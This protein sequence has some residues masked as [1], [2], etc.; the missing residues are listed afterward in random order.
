MA[1][2]RKRGRLGAVLAAAC[3]AAGFW[4]AWS[5][6]NFEASLVT[7]VA[8]IRDVTLP[9]DTTL[10][11]GAQTKVD[12]HYDRD[13]RK[14]TLHEGEAFFAVSFDA[15]PFLV[16][17]QKTLVTAIGTQFEVHVAHETVRVSVL[18][19]AVIVS[20]VPGS[21]VP[22][23]SSGSR[24]L[25]GS[26]EESE[27][28]SVTLVAH[29]QV[30]ADAVGKLGLP[31]GLAPVEPGAWRSGKRTYVD[32]PLREIVADANRYS[33]RSIYIA[34]R[35]LG[36]RIMSLSFHADNLQQMLNDLSVATP[37]DVQYTEAGA[38]ILRSRSTNGRRAKAH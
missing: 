34:D 19:G 31:R 29:Q 37:V 15:R 13:V 17:S 35:K 1:G 24:L 27:P 21:I 20:P 2:L 8:Q 36:E 9:D 33:P 11:L 3:A 30:T 16:E 23:A 22:V 10:T 18:E 32:T 26:E 7:G 25:R 4:Y 12:V 14:L 28:Q 38:V 6:P 5:A